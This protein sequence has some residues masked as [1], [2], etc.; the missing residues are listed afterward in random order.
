MLRLGQWIETKLVE[1]VEVDRWIVSFQ[2]RLF[3]VKNHTQMKFTPGKILRL[4]VVGQSP[5]ELR[6]ADHKS[7]PRCKLD[8]LA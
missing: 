7:G 6:V 8:L 4:Q 5:L 1:A 3:Q 2:G